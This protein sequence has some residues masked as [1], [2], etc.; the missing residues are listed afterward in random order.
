M[1]SM[2]SYLFPVGTIWMIRVG[3]KPSGG[4]S[5]KVMDDSQPTSTPVNLFSILTSNYIWGRAGGDFGSVLHV[6][7]WQIARPIDR[8]VMHGG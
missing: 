5:G 6:H 7:A 1:K 3:T 8:H 4:G 2:M